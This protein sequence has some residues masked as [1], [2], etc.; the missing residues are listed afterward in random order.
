[1]SDHANP[2]PGLV[3]RPEWAR[4]LGRCDRTVQRWQ[5]EGKIVTVKVGGRVFVDV[6]ATAERFRATPYIV[7]YKPRRR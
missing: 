3:H 1:M 5:D 4:A 6:E 2:L 7:R